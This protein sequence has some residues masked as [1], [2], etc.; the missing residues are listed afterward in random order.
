MYKVQ[1]SLNEILEATAGKVIVEGKKEFNK[2]C[3]DTRK[4]ES[5]N[6]YLAI[7]SHFIQPLDIRRS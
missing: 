7:L 4:I 2:I 1:L 6:N 5:D 3:I